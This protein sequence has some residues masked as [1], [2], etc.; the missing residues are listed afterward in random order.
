MAWWND[1]ANWFSDNPVAQQATT[2]AQKVVLL[3]ETPPPLVT[4]TTPISSNG[5]QAQENSNFDFTK[6]F[7]T[8]VGLG[9]N[10]VDAKYIKAAAN[11]QNNARPIDEPSVPA[12]VDGVR[13]AVTVDAD[14]S[15]SSNVGLYVLGGFGLLLAFS[16]IKR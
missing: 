13:A 12:N 7:D 1:V 9:T 16:F 5:V 8:I 10:Y 6:L 2:K 11:S 14:T 15:T 4:S 3:Q